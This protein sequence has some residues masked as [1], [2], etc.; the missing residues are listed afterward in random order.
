MV[1]TSDESIVSWAD[2]GT[3]FVVKDPE[4]LTAKVIPQFFIFLKAANLENHPSAE[5]AV[6]RKALEAL[7]IVL[8]KNVQAYLEEPAAVE[9]RSNVDGTCLVSG[10][11]NDK[12]RTDQFITSHQGCRRC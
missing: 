6:F 9:A 8:K 1:N 3:T 5:K 12:D 7:T 2:D 11:V 4:T 10:C